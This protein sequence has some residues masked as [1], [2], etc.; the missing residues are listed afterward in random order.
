MTLGLGHLQTI[1]DPGNFK[2][3]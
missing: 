1:M 2:N 3:F